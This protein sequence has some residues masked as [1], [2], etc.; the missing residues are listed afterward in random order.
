MFLIIRFLFLFLIGF[1]VLR[2]FSTTVD[3]YWRA[4]IGAFFN[5]VG[6]NGDLMMRIIIILTVIVS[7]LFVLYKWF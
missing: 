5:W 1:W 6:V 7:L 3:F 2:F 4:T